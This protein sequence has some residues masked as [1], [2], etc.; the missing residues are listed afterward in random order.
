[1]S[2]V[3]N[4]LAMSRSRTIQ[5]RRGSQ[6]DFVQAL[7]VLGARFPAWHSRFDGQHQ[8]R[9]D[10]HGV[11]LSCSRETWDWVFGLPNHVVDH[12]TA[13]AQ[14]P[15]QAWECVCADGRVLCVGHLF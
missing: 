11:F 13:L 2:Y 8:N 6:S 4:A 7:R 1:M 12:R 9:E 3:E 14:H 15:F 5:G 10:L